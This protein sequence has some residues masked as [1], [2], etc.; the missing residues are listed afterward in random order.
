MRRWPGIS[1]G[2]GRR[3]VLASLLVSASVSAQD[4]GARRAV[5]QKIEFVRQLAIDSP[6]SRRIAAS[7]NVAARR[8]FE[9][10][11]ALFERA[12]AALRAGELAVAEQAA[13]EAIWSFGRARQLV[14][15]DVNRSIVQRVRYQQLMQSAERIVPTFRMHL[16]HAGMSDSPD[17]S[18][19]LGL[20]DEARSLAGAERLDDANRL[21]LQAERHLLVGLNRM[22]GDR[23]LVVSA[24][25]DSPAKELDYE[26]ERHRSLAELVPLAVDELKPSEDARVLIR[27]FVERSQALR[28]QAQAQAG[29]S[30]H[31]PALASVREA[32]NFLQR[33]LTAAGLVIPTP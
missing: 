28:V 4:I 21:L 11:Q 23:T 20:I 8:H 19:A 6:A 3:A 2:C 17:L 5:E 12:G 16:S 30:Q 27:R 15:D 33:A 32:I 9:E 18:A 29:R 24:H 13:N 7:D 10:G 14:P 25:F 1:R 31:E 26:L 22:I